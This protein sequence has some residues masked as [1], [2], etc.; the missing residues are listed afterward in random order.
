M[1]RSLIRDFPSIK[2]KW[3]IGKIMHRSGPMSYNIE[4]NDGR[5]AR[6]HIDHIRTYIGA[7]GTYGYDEYQDEYSQAA[8]GTDESVTELVPASNIDTVVFA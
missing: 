8:P 4:F 1:G 3:L 6:R 2:I 7:T 5:I